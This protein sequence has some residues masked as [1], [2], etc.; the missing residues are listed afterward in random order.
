MSFELTATVRTDF[1][2]GFARRARMAGKIPGVIYGHG[3]DPIHVEL[4]YHDTF[5]IVK[6]VKGAVI[7]IKGL[8]KD[9]TVQVK[10][11]QKHPVKR[12]LLHIDLLVV[13]K[14]EAAAAEA[15]A[16]AAEAEFAAHEAELEAMA[17]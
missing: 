13:N 6:D 14:A 4:P 17:E 8:D 2:K 7:D 12:D 10:D 3:I 9:V 16:E 11:V 5:L 1:G 15:A